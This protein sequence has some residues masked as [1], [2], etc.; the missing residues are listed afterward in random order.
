MQLRLGPMLGVLVA[1]VGWCG[2][3]LLSGAAVLEVPRND[4]K[5]AGLA[6]PVLIAVVLVVLVKYVLLVLLPIGGRVPVADWRQHLP[7][8]Y[9][10]V[11][12]R[13]LLLMPLWGRWAMMLALGVGRVAPGE[14]PRLTT[15]GGGMNLPVILIHWLAVT[16]LTVFYVS[17]SAVDIPLCLLIALGVLYGAYLTAFIL[18]RRF[19]GQTQATVAAVGA[20]A[21]LLFLVAYLP[22]AS[23]I[24]W[25]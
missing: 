12:D 24:Y 6:L 21:E 15:M 7:Y 20:V 17:G 18:A 13:P 4:S 11:I 3:R 10:Q 19:G 2:Y 25:Y 16:G 14:S 5:G 1:D 22:V 8:L 9:P 23:Y